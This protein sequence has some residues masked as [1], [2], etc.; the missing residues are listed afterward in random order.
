VVDDGLGH[1]LELGAT[2]IVIIVIVIVVIGLL[3]IKVII[4][5]IICVLCETFFVT[6]EWTLS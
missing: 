2:D 1:A 3:L 6:T 5:I 4:V